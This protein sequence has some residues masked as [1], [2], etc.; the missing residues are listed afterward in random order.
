MINSK[1]YNLLALGFFMES[2]IIQYNLHRELNRC[3]EV[4]DKFRSE[5]VGFNESNRYYL[6]TIYSD[7]KDYS[8]AILSNFDHSVN[9]VFNSNIQKVKLIR[10]KLDG[11]LQ[12]F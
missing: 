4:L 2:K 12:E 3:I 8:K 9:E 5:K 6:N 1:I 10:V 11:L 7:I